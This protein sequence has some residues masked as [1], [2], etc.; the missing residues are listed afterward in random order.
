M[1]N[2]VSAGTALRGRFCAGAATARF[3]VGR[4]PAGL[5]LRHGTCHGRSHG[6]FGDMVYTLCCILLNIMVFGHDGG[7][8]GRTAKGDYLGTVWAQFLGGNYVKNI[9]A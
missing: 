7:K 9:R 5:R 8:R 3:L 1:L 6:V 2:G 4:V